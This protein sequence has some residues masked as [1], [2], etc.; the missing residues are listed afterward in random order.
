LAN[1]THREKCYE[2][3]SGSGEGVQIAVR[4]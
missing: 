3:H 1:L 4:G 2:K